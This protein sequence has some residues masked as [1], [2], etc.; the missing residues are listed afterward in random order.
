LS[1]DFWRNTVKASIPASRQ[2]PSNETIEGHRLQ[3]KNS[4]PLFET[5]DPFPR[6]LGLCIALVVMLELERP[7]F[8]LGYLHDLEVVC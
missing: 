8:L 4:S 6:S 1:N 2:L 7:G 3:Y 5:N